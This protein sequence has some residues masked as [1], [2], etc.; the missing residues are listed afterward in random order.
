MLDVKW[1]LLFLLEARMIGKYGVM[2][3]MATKVMK[4]E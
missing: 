2:E 3:A 1:T 4:Y